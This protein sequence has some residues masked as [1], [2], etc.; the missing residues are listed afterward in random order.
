M[1]ENFNLKDKVALVTGGSRGIGRAIVTSLASLGAKVYFLYCNNKEAAVEVEQ[2]CQQQQ[3]SA[4]ALQVDICEREKVFATIEEIINLEQK[5]DILVNNSG[6]IRDGLFAALEPQQISDVINTNVIG[7]MNV[8]QAVVPSM[9]R[10]RSGKIINISSV[11]AEKGGRG[12]T[13]YA[14]AKGAVNAFTKSLAVELAKRNITVNAVAPGVIETAMSQEVRDLAGD[15]ALDQILLK[16]Y[17]KAQDIA[18][19]VAFLASPLAD[20][21]TGEIIHVDGGFKF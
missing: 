3:G 8:T 15:Q 16:R 9:M 2:A 1:L 21:I 19:M 4:K 6:I 11:A 10:K 18:N 7:M 5:I 13:N 12:Q 20:Y 17:G 14:A